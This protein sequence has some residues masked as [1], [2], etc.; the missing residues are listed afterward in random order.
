MTEKFK[1]WG[2]APLP[3]PLNPRI[4]V[5]TK[6][7]SFKISVHSLFFSLFYFTLLSS[8]SSSSSLR[9]KPKY[10]HS[11][12]SLCFYQSIKSTSVTR[13]KSDPPYDN[14]PIK[15]SFLIVTKGT[16]MEWLIAIFSLSIHGKCR[17][18][19]KKLFPQLKGSPFT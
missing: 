13:M 18:P 15:I 5:N 7:S 8:S 3:Y 16:H 19:Y 1:V 11:S 2:I 10:E 14:I 4:L 6:I 12:S 9:T 17:N